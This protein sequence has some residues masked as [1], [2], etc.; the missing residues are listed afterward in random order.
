MKIVKHNIKVL[1][2]VIRSYRSYSKPDIIAKLSPCLHDLQFKTEFDNIMKELREWAKADYERNPKPFKGGVIRAKDG[3]RV[4][5]RAECI[6]YNLLLELGIPFRY[7]PNMKFKKMNKDGE[8]EEYYESPDFL[9]KCPDGTYIIIEHAGLLTLAQYAD[10]LARKLQI[11][12]LNG[13]WIGR[14]LFVTSENAD[15]GIDS[16]QISILLEQIRMRFPYL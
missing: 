13:Y 6:I 5:S 9:I 15:G 2:K 10:D 8:L 11:Y 4:R 3:T 12:Q 16:Q 1:Q 7:D 14:S